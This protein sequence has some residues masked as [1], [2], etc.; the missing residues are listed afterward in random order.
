[1]SRKKIYGK[2]L[3]FIW[4]LVVY[5][6][7]IYCTIHAGIGAAPWDVLALGAARHLPVSYGIVV[8]VIN[9]ILV[10]LDWKLGERVGFGTVYDALLTGNFTDVWLRINPLGGGHGFAAGVAILVAGLFAQSLGIYFAMSSGQGCG[11]KDALLLA[12]GKRF[13]KVPI[14]L[15]QILL[16]AAALAGGA[17]LG[18][19]VG[20]GTVIAVACSG[21]TL[22]IVFRLLRYE[23]RETVHMDFFETLRVLGK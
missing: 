8:T 20:I 3:R 19:P 23:P 1:M 18:G 12:A 22:Q 6:F 9:I 15:V 13:P 11:P 2:W 10:T 7:G 4:G 17:L 21:V 14:G 16:F 5:S